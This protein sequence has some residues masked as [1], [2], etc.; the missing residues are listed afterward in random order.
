MNLRTFGS[1]LASVALTASSFS[2]VASA[3][4]ISE[5]VDEV[6]I[7]VDE[8]GNLAPENEN[9]DKP[10]LTRAGEGTRLYLSSIGVGVCTGI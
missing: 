3:A 10:L 4:S 8:N 1:L 5:T 2:N 9:E 7:Y 6:I